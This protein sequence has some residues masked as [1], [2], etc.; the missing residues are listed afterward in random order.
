MNVAE[1]KRLLQD[2]PDEAEVIGYDS[3]SQFM[4]PITRI[5]HDPEPVEKF[6]YGT[7]ELHAED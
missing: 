3:N 2:L 5:E 4:E 7:V 1:L 6:P